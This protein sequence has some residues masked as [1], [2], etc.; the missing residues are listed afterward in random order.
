M[1]TSAADSRAE[2]LE[3]IRQSGRCA[4]AEV[5]TRADALSAIELGYDGLILAGNEA[6]GRVS[7]ESAF[8][9]LQ[10][11]LAM[12]G[13]PRV[14]VRGGI[15]PNAAAG[16]VAAGAAG[17]VLDGA[18]LLSKESPLPA[19][20]RERISAWDGVES[21]LL[22]ASKGLAIRCYAPPTSEVARR[23]RESEALD[24][25]SW[26]SVAEALIGWDQGQA[27]PVG[28]DTAL[29][30]E[31]AR[32]HVTVGGI[33]QAVEKAIDEGIRLAA[34][35]GP[36]SE[37]SALAISHGT[38]FP[39]VQ[40]P[41]TRVS[42]RP[43]FAKAVADGGGLPFLA[44][45]MMRGGEVRSLLTEATKMLAGQP[46][47]TGILGFLPPEHRLEQTEVILE[48]RP[49]FVLIAG[50]RPDQAR[51]FEQAGITT[52]LHVPSPGLL[53][54]FLRDGARRFVLEGR[55]CGGHVGPRSSFVL[56][57]QA[58]R[59]L[60]EAFD[61]GLDPREIHML[62][63][64][65]IH[66]AR[67][68]AV[69]SAFT[70]P[71]ANRGVRVGTLVGTAYLFT[72]EAVETGAIVSGFQDEAINCSE[73]VLLETGPGHLVRVSPT[74]F[75]DRF[76]RE[77]QRL[78]AEGKSAEA[79]RDYLEGLNVGRLRVAAKGVDRGEG[80][81]A[82]FTPVSL[83]D[84]FENG[85]YMLGQAATL[86][87]QTSTI[88]E[89]HEAIANGSTEWIRESVGIFDPREKK[90]AQPSDIAIIGM[91]AVVP[92]AANVRTFWEN[93]LK[94]Q[95]SITEVPA[96]RWDWRLYY[97]ADPKAPDKIISKWGGFV[98]DIPFDPLTY[99]MPPSSLPSIEPLHLITLEA[100]R[101]ALDDAGY[102]D[103][104]FP[105]ERTAVVLGAGGGAA[106]LSMGYAFRSYLPLLDTVMP[107]VGTEA[108]EKVA[109]C[110]RNG[111]R[112]RS[113]EFS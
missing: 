62:Y 85:L 109:Q 51:Q 37:G 9:Y 104:A 55:E 93:T 49:P 46:W 31:L 113:R 58:S 98:P 47:G 83:G 4:L 42:D 3:E 65:G 24:P 18:L 5:T 32:K 106:Q 25:A 29:A 81:G 69:V 110:S 39:I 54:Q 97:D 38:R 87:D 84:Q 80:A 67:S 22:G 36:L 79:I 33:V 70:A 101:A 108:M 28:Q 19:S 20:I 2:T 50:G 21:S 59:V 75:T 95:D 12:P 102:K 100:V 107:G 16:C 68:G 71:L 74:P 1:I 45:A 111:P 105:R 76:E 57:E 27:W 11:V 88:E 6:G 34:S 26:K 30:A 17:V 103:R 14:W 77:R 96:D 44:L 41:M 53:T 23:L 91:S 112:I 10:A 7:D 94:S 99:G 8:I 48:A 13:A 35:I 15:G 66:D 86:R 90:K 63:A 73:T 43:A 52:Y 82:L 60:T 64:G 72:R 78:L 89:L 56:W 61:K 40:G 92:G